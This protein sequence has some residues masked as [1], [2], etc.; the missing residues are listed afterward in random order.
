VGAR[1]ARGVVLILTLF[2]IL[3]TY[4]LVTQLTLGTAVATQTARNVADRIR[5]EAACRSAAKQVLDTLAENGGGTAAADAAGALGGA[6]GLG[7]SADSGALGG[8]SGEEGGDQEEADDSDSFA[9]AWARPMRVRMDDIEIT[10]WVQDENG[11]F[12]L[13]GLIAED[14]DYRRA[15]RDRCVRIL[16]RLREDFDDDLSWDDANRITQEIIDWLEGRTRDPDGYPRPLRYS[17]P[18]DSDQSLMDSLGELLMLEHVDENLYYDQLRDED[19]IAPGL[20]SAF[21]VWTTIDLEPPSSG[22]AGIDAATASGE[23]GAG[24]AADQGVSGAAGGSLSGG[25]APSPLGSAA[26][27]GV[28]GAPGAGGGETDSETALPAEGGLAGAESGQAPIGAKI[29]LNT[30]LP[31]VLEGILEDTDLPKDLADEIVEY[32]NEVDEE[33]VQRRK[34]QEVDPDVQALE[35]ALYGDQEPEPTLH[36]KTLEDLD[37]LDTYSRLS[38]TDQQTFQELVTTQSDVFSVYLFARIPPSDWRQEKRYQE[39]PGPVLR[40]R[41][42]YWRRKVDQGVKF[43][44][45]VPWQEVPLTRWRIP[46]DQ[47]HLPS[48]QP[49]EFF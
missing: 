43:I 24:A 16:D 6:A 29:N 13:L 39:P 12:N 49:P 14:E 45:I 42:V 3:I 40:L 27:T 30:A 23:K 22:E 44:P 35:Q 36:F 4:A 47:D 8:A 46:D 32:R 1:G 37:Q 38:S 19:R 34:D 11:K 15:S 17:N 5:M 33:E 28:P 25:G 7:E 26:A 9:D 21:T 18:E 10:A 20:E 48:F 41:A 31:A 2:V